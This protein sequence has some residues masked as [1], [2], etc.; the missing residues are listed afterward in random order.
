MSIEKERKIIQFNLK[1]EADNVLTGKI[2]LA[3]FNNAA[4]DFRKKYQ[5]F[6]SKEEYVKSFEMEHKGLS[7]TDCNFTN[8][9]SIYL[10]LQESYDVK[11]KNN[12]T[13]AGNMV[14]I[15]PLLYE[16]VTSNPFKSEERKYPVDF[17]Y[18][19]EKTYILKLELPEGAQVAELPKPL[20]MK[21]QDGSAS[22]RYRIDANANFVQLSYK[23]TLDKAVYTEKEYGDL[24]ALFSELVKKNAEQIVIK[25]L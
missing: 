13:T 10:P 20:S 21:L 6:N 8:L 15:N 23:F 1:L 4:I 16:Q 22:V 14:Y 11:I 9:D 5:K 12:V 25:T 7:V 18:P 19:S 2:T 3:N 17:V 24:R